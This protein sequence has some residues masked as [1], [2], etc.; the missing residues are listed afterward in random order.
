MQ[1]D[2]AYKILKRR[3]RTFLNENDFTYIHAESRWKN[4]LLSLFFPSINL[5]IGKLN[6][7]M[8]DLSDHLHDIEQRR[9]NEKDKKP[10]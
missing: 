6:S 7:E 3:V 10:D 5:S 8:R 9:E 2:E 4:F 1:T